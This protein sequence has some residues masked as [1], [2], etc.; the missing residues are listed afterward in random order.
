[1]IDKKA[2][3][4][5]SQLD[6]TRVAEVLDKLKANTGLLALFEKQGKKDTERAF[7]SMALT[8]VAREAINDRLQTAQTDLPLSPSA[9]PAQVNLEVP[10]NATLEQIVNALETEAEALSA[11]QVQPPEIRKPASDAAEDLRD[12]AHRHEKRMEILSNL[13]KTCPE[14]PGLVIALRLASWILVEGDLNQLPQ[15]WNDFAEEQ[16]SATQLTDDE[17][18][19]QFS[20]QFVIM[21]ARLERVLIAVARLEAYIQPLLKES[22]EG[23][24]PIRALIA[25]L[26]ATVTDMTNV[27]RAYGVSIDNIHILSPVSKDAEEVDHNRCEDFLAMGGGETLPLK[28]MQELVT[29]NPAGENEEILTDVIRWG[30]N[31]NGNPKRP[32]IVTT[33]VENIWL[34]GMGRGT[35]PEFSTR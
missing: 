27:V 9:Q 20:T 4:T 34:A 26:R 19:E 3:N 16:S 18:G 24:L 13:I 32:S 25:A 35:N 33:Y 10:E 23:A 21:F 28:E 22:D 29:V 15:I 2:E 14:N 7:R 31:L 5:G 12:W 30:W 1:M 6:E 8:I 11:S 17:Y